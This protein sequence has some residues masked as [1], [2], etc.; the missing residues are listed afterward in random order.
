MRKSLARQVFRLRLCTLARTAY[1]DGFAK[2][3]LRASIFAS[4]YNIVGVVCSP[5]QPP[6][7]PLQHR[8]R[9][10]DIFGQ[11]HR[12][13][14]SDA[15]PAPDGLCTP[16]SLRPPRPA[17]PCRTWPDSVYVVSY[18]YFYRDSCFARPAPGRIHTCMCAEP[19]AP[20]SCLPCR[21]RRKSPP[22]RLRP[23]A[24]FVQDGRLPGQYLFPFFFSEELSV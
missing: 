9:T 22:R 19:C 3:P 1:I 23:C 2:M 14:L 18:I 24:L 8:H 21:L 15:A 20:G 11:C 5:A 12:R 4:W 10:G 7:A 6:A 16:V 17:V 13:L